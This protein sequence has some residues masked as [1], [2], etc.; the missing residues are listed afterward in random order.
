MNC[1]IKLHVELGENMWTLLTIKWMAQVVFIS[2]FCLHCIVIDFFFW[3]V[4]KPNQ[5][6][7]KLINWL[8][9]RVTFKHC[10][11][12]DW[13]HF[14]LLYATIYLLRVFNCELFWSWNCLFFF[15]LVYDF[16]CFSQLIHCIVCFLCVVL[17]FSALSHH[18]W[19]LN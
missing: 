19:A 4:F 5:S 10:R 15:H 8:K 14:K 12:K 13:F 17:S 2:Y 1:K 18:F 7:K 16:V 11:H 3:N 6:R 9:F